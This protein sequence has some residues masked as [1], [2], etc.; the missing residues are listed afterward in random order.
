MLPTFHWAYA[1]DVDRYEYEPARARR[2]LDEAGHPDPGNGQPRFTVSFKTSNNQFR[3]AIASVIASMLREVGIGVE[4]RVNEFAT[5]FADIKKG[6]FQLFMM[7]IP[8]ISEPDLY[9]HFFATR[10]IPTRDNLD[11]GANRVRY[12]N[13]EL[14]R[15]LDEGRRTLDRERRRQIYAEVQ[16]ILAREVPVVSLWHEDNVAALRREVRGFALLPTALLGALA[17][18]YKIGAKR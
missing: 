11:A 3:V 17:H 2:L 4:L 10:R 12:R 15:L 9:I 1:A 14:D 13:P 7:Q 8:E 5:F 6:N 18:T 16:R